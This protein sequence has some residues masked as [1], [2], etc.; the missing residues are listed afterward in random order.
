MPRFLFIITPK[1]VGIRPQYFLLLVM[2]KG[3]GKRVFL[4]LSDHPVDLSPTKIAFSR[5][6]IRRHPSVEG[7]FA[8]QRYVA[9]S[10]LRRGAKPGVGYSMAQAWSNTYEPVLSLYVVFAGAYIMHE[11]PGLPTKQLVAAPADV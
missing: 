11:P 2:T 9:S 1:A 7:N 4:G 5:G 3:G 8:P 10:P 6:P